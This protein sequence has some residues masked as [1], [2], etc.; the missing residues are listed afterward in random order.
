M[1][2]KMKIIA[3]GAGV[4]ILSTSIVPTYLQT[5]HF[6]QAAKNKDGVCEIETK[7]GEFT[8]NANG[9]EI[10][11]EKPVDLFAI[12]DGSPSFTSRGKFDKALADLTDLVKSLPDKSQV[13]F[14][15]Y[16]ENNKES[17][18]SNKTQGVTKLLSKSDALEFLE[19]VKN[20]WIND[21][22]GY[23]RLRSPFVLDK[24]DSGFLSDANDLG[25]AKYMNTQTFNDIEEAYDTYSNKNETL[26]VVQFTDEWEPN[27]NIDT[28]FVDWA[29]KNAKTFMSVLY[30]TENL[31]DTKSETSMKEANHPNIY[32]SY[33]VDDSERSK[34]IIEQFKNTGIEKTQPK[35]N[36]NVTPE[37]GI[38]LK[39]VKLVN[40]DGQEENL[41]I[42]DNKVNVE[43]DLPKDGN[44]TVKVKA[45]G[46]VPENRKV[47]AT[48]SI[49][50]K[51]VGK[52]EIEFE[53]CK[54]DVKPTVTKRIEK[55]PFKTQRV[56]DKT[57]KEGEEKVVVKG[58]EGEKEITTTVTPGIAGVEGKVT[59]NLN[60]NVNAGSTSTTEVKGRSIFMP[61][62]GSGSTAWGERD[63]IIEDLDAIINSLSDKDQIQLA[64][65]E[66][67]NA[68]S[69][70]SHGNTDNSAPTTVMM[71]KEKAV[72]LIKRVKELIADKH[73]YAWRTAVKELDVRDKTAEAGKQYGEI[74]EASRDKNLTPVII[75][76]TD[77]W[78]DQEDIDHDFAKWAKDHAKTFM[79]VIYDTQN[80]TANKK[81]IEAGHPNIFLTVPQGKNLTKEERTSGILKQIQATTVEKVTKNEKLN[82]KVNISGDGVTVTK[83]KLKG[84]VEKDLPIVDGKV[85]FDEKL[86]DGDYKV[87]YEATG[88]GTLKAEVSVNDKV[89]DNKTDT[90]KSVAGQQGKTDVTEQVIKEPV[91]EVIHVGVLG[92]KEET[93]NVDIPFETIYEDT[94]TLP[95]GETQVKQEGVVG[96]KQIKKVWSTIKGEK[97]GDP[98]VT[99]SVTK[100]KVDKIVLRGT[101][102]KRTVY[103]RIVD[104]EGKVLQDKTKVSDGY[105]DAEYSVTKPVLA[106]YEIELK[107]GMKE[108]GKI[109][110]EDVVVDYVA[111]KIGQDVTLKYVADGKDLKDAEVLSQGARVGTKFEKEVEKEIT[112]DGVLY[113][114]VGL[115]LENAD[116]AKS[117]PEIN[118]TKVSGEVNDTKQVYVAKYEMV[119]SKPVTVAFVDENGK[120]LQA[121]QN[122]I[123]EDQ[124]LGTEYN[125]KPKAIEKDGVKYTVEKIT[126]GNKEVKEIKGKSSEEAAEYTVHYKKVPEKVLPKTSA[127]EQ[128]MTL[129]GL[130][131]TLAS[132]FGF[133][134]LK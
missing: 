133:R 25:T 23:L 60:F 6:A 67:N 111:Y 75:Q 62:D 95:E 59:N 24:T 118:G 13:V 123:K 97:Q 103:Y 73:D 22:Q 43:K 19:K 17:Y 54:D 10:S 120:E 108:S 46:L 85:A 63:N 28:T 131:M 114:F 56:E 98:T 105:K 20:F 4:G 81:M 2:K 84:P 92:S 99:E 40:P 110:N 29:K 134:R 39:E 31:R 53:G 45:D 112:K 42:S 32:R 18:T 79:S 83:A 113:R 61:V 16:L 27:E 117:K 3:I 49:A 127:A 101:Q 5:T 86:D 70:R 7:S 72:K 69:Y 125:F 36:I 57:L 64:F 80:S 26:S 78:T 107:E 11:T 68:S 128:G 9:T 115:E 93:E 66:D 74:F 121:K 126:L 51:E 21:P 88:N 48:A 71:N 116:N 33:G 12:L 109:A 52:T 122:L 129:L 90:L 100:E 55:L 89:V 96:V 77:G 104:A 91:D 124:K 34:K 15:T 82:V 106:G 119:K 65:Y 44:W 38:T 50:G 102:Q 130:L 47:T 35:V 30:Y 87:E 94:D 132:V 8:F 58:E 41:E 76:L 37:Q 1:K 14:A